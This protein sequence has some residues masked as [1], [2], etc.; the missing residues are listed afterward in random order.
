LYSEV[1]D[2]SFFRN[3]AFHLLNCLVL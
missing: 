1:E 2:S 3:R